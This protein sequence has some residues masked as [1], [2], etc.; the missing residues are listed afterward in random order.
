MKEAVEFE[1][2]YGD[3]VRKV[4]R[5]TAIRS[6]E[7]LMSWEVLDNCKERKFF[8]SANSSK[9]S[10]FRWPFYAY[11]YNQMEIVI[12][13]LADPEYVVHY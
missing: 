10:T 4:F 8:R 1:R 13:P 9:L 2:Q 11:A 6:N 3:E 7:E 12:S 5:V